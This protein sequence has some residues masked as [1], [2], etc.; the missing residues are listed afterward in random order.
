M[1]AHL[2]L[3]IVI[4]HYNINMQL[5]I[6]VDTDADSTNII[7]DISDEIACINVRPQHQMVGSELLSIHWLEN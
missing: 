2:N 1:K 7:H 6:F 5:E 4:S 3:S